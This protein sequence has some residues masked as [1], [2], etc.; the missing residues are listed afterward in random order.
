VV[1]RARRTSL[2]GAAQLLAGWV[3][4]LTARVREPELEWLATDDLTTLPDDRIAAT[5][6]AAG[7]AS[8][9]ARQRVETRAD[10]LRAAAGAAG[11]SVLVQ[12]LA[13]HVRATVDAPIRL[14]GDLRALRR[15][16]DLDALLEREAALVDEHGARL[17][18]ALKALAGLTV[19]R[20][21]VE[22]FEDTGVHALFRDVCARE[23]RPPTRR[24]AVGG[25]ARVL[26]AILG[27]D[28]IPDPRGL[29]V[30]QRIARNSDDD[31]WCRRAALT[32]VRGLEPAIAL[33]WLEHALDD[34][35]SGE[36][37]LVRARAIE[38]LLEPA[39]LTP[40]ALAVAARHADDPAELVRFELADGLGR[41]WAAGDPHAGGLLVRMMGDH[42]SPRTR[43]RAIVA[44]GARALDHLAPRVADDPL[45]ATFA[46]DVVAA[47]G[48]APLP[49]LL[50]GALAHVAETGAPSLARAASLALVRRR[51]RPAGIAELARSLAAL[52]SGE[53]TTVTLPHGADPLDLA[54][55]LLP[56]ASTGHG[57]S[58]EPGRRRVT[59]RRGDLLRPR[60]WR[61]LHELRNP[62]PTKRQ[63]ISHALA[64][65][66]TG[67]IRV[68]PCKLAEESATGVPGER[69]R[70]GREDG[71][72]PGLPPVDAY[73][74][75]LGRDQ[76]TVVAPEGVTTVEPPASGRDRMRAWLRTTWGYAVFDELRTACV[77]EVDPA[78][79]GRYV[80]AFAKLGFR[81]VSTALRNGPWGGYYAAALLDPV[82]YLL[83][84]R[85]NSLAHLAMV[86]FL[87]TLVVLG[88]GV[89]VQSV[90]RRARRDVPLVLGGWGTRGKSGTERLKAG[91]LE[92]L[93]IP[94]LSKT[95]GCEAMVLHAPPGGH[96]MEL[97][98]FRPY[99]RATIW[100]Q[101][102]VV[103]M[104]PQLG[105]RA[106]L[107]ECM[108]LN[109][110]YVDLLQTRWMRDDLST[111]TNAYPDHE[112]VMGPTGMDVARAIAGF[113]P[114]DATVLTTEDNML[115]ELEDVGRARG[116]T[117]VQVPRVERDLV[118]TELLDRMPHVEHP[119]NVA[120]V[121]AVGREL[122]LA[123][124]E[125]I[126]L[127]GEHVVPDLGA[128]SITPSA[129]H[130]GRDVTF[131]NGM[132]ANDTLSFRHNWRRAGFLTHDH[133]AA[134]ATWLVTVIN[135]RA[136]RVARSRVFAQVCA[137]DAAA[138]R[139]VLI[140]T[141]VRGFMTYLDEAVAKR[142]QTTVLGSP[143]KVDT[144]FAHLRIVEP[145]ALGEACATHLGA[146]EEKR[147][148]W[149]AAMSGL[150]DGPVDWTKAQ[151]FAAGRV[152]T[153]A[154][155]LEAACGSDGAGL[156]DA[157]V[158]AT[159]RWVAFRAARTAPEADVRTL[160]AELVRSSF[161]VVDDPGSTGDQTMWRAITSCP[162]G[163]TVR[164]MG[165]QNIKG[166]GLD[167]AYQ[168]VY[169]RELHKG[170]TDLASASPDRQVRGLEA[171]EG[172]PFGSALACDAALGVL[173]GLAGDP[174]LGARIRRQVE[175]VE[176]RRRDLVHARGRAS[177][178]QGWW[179]AASRWVE[180]LIDPFDAIWRRRRARQV[181]RDLCDRRISHP[182]AQAWLQELTKRQKGGW[183]GKG[184][185]LH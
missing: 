127:M 57:F 37:W 109:P 79:R 121:A 4:P 113:S 88:R 141:N 9:E 51:P 124:V 150:D 143:D 77:A 110:L 133:H 62:G 108:A 181:F 105:A 170:L 153:V 161:V 29:H 89:Q 173:G 142:L 178:K 128:L 171:V 44:A 166:T 123:P 33:R 81:T 39:T 40:R 95:T 69:I 49:D 28:E 167:F 5:L 47:T 185:R 22:A 66:D 68:P 160:Y 8:L 111:L 98:L 132:S 138:H 30:L 174:V 34:T 136:D 129:R 116:S 172:N 97:F 101:V 15:D 83:S 31:P 35:V 25:L 17:E 179:A 14:L 148:E 45:V 144:L 87:L 78:L 72:S 99:D 20:L 112:D 43:A 59:V 102:D 46:L 104:G 122:G 48:E 182:R 74:H 146:T 11:G 119:A 157:L 19:E 118:A 126:G 120:L 125:A 175:R 61:L 65:A 135:N 26:V 94:L 23:R 96:A 2:S 56:A 164:V 86:V 70:V 18:V 21:G 93:G 100:E 84:L 50:T 158:A 24:S 75:A 137:E 139:H 162:P 13:R 154:A 52:R 58:L 147:Q 76:V 41:R 32:V 67:S 114:R 64:R 3:D 159:A 169:W 149:T 82:A 54:E 168:W 177:A 63:S 165:I 134:P 1:I 140:G 85:S 155:A 92:G 80:A 152:R 130:L 115:A 106:V 42:P 16:L 6:V 55:A 73:L 156:A 60:L 107:W 180:R 103:R 145:S 36:A 12:V 163:A 27:R 10:G 90:V 151:A 53:T 38:L 71:W 117:V 91:M 184:R 183:L 7:R 176:S 131:V